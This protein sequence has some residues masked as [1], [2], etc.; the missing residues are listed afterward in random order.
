M[1]MTIQEFALK[2]GLPP[3]TL[4][5]YEN[6]NLLLPA[7]RGEN[8]YRYYSD[9][10]I[11][12]ARLIQSFRQSSVPMDEIRILLQSTVSEQEIL[13]DKWRQKVEDN[14]NSL[15]V[16]KQYL[17]GLR[18]GQQALQMVNWE[19]ASVIVWFP[20]SLT[21]SLHPYHE[22]IELNKIRLL[23]ANVNVLADC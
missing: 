8:G 6:K 22:P 5:F 20:H 2:T 7:A 1:Q 12:I 19:E 21:Q 23:Q 17:S 18:P 11:S 10:Q 13:L 16:A 4:R 9:E 15:Q 14:L 3:T